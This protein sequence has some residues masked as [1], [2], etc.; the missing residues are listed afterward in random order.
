MQDEGSMGLF[1]QKREPVGRAL[2]RERRDGR[3]GQVL[4]ASRPG[5]GLVSCL[6]VR[7]GVAGPKRS[8]WELV[9]C[10]VRRSVLH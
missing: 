4:S 8:F 3:L 6:Q 10:R 7:K 2:E 9:Q 1:A 5:E